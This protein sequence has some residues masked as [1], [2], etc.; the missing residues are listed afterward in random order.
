MMLKKTLGIWLM[1]VAMVVLVTACGSATPPPS[2]TGQENHVTEEIMMDKDNAGEETVAEDNADEAM[3]GEAKSDEAMSD[4]TV[5]EE[6][7][8][9]EAK[10]EEPMTEEAMPDETMTEEAMIDEAKSDEATTVPDWFN[11]ELTDVN[12]GETFRIADFK[13]KVVLIETMAVWCPTC[14]RQAKEIQTLH[15]MLGE[16][17]DFVSVTLDV[18]P[19]ETEEIL[20]AY[21]DQNGF[22]WNYAV[23][24]HEVNR[25]LGNL[26]SAQ[27]LNPPVSPLLIIDQQGRA[28]GLPFGTIKKATN[29]KPTIEAYLNGE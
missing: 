21:T 16:R 4:E 5:T 9:D 2:T 19:N 13:G 24:P 15:E 25:A 22:D 11:V 18:D 26:Y 1:L 14:A 7:M 29:L 12:T 10:S 28:F 27:Y 23:S 8:I 17:D 6:V 20:K 3:M